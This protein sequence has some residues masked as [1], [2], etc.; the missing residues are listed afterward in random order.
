MNWLDRGIGKISP[1]WGMRR[2]IARRRLD[3]L[4][5][6]QA[7][8]SESRRSFE[9]VSGDRLR[10][11]FSTTTL[12]ADSIIAS[13]AKAV[14]QNVR[15][16]EYNSGFVAGPLKRIVDNVIGTGIRFQAA[17]KAAERPGDPP[18]S[19]DQAEAFN[20]QVERLWRKW[21][22]QAD[23]RLISSFFELQA[24]V[25]GAL[26]RD[27]EA[28]VVGRSSGRPGRLISYCHELLEIDRLGTPPSLIGDRQV[29]NGIRFDSE[30]VQQSYYVL[31]SHPRD[32]LSALAGFRSEDYEEIPAWNPNGTR[33]VL[34]L[35][36]PLRPEQTRGFSEFA[37][38]LKDLQD[39]DRYREAEIMA[40]LEDACLTGFVKT[41]TPSQFQDDTTTDNQ[42]VDSGSA[43]IHEFAPNKWHYLKPGEDVKIHAPSRPG[44]QFQNTLDLLLSGTANAMNIPPEILSQNWKNMNYSNARTVLLQWYLFCRIVQAYIITHYCIPTYQNV[45]NG[46]VA[47]GLIEARG[48]GQWQDE[49]SESTWTPPGWQW[50]DPVKEAQGTQIDLENSLD[51]LTNVLAARGLDIEETLE[52]RAWELK[53]IK[54]LEEK[55]GVKFPSPDRTGKAEE[56]GEQKQEELPTLQ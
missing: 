51:T 41:D 37:A 39:L 26:F 14:R 29:L 19:Q 3:W 5:S 4:R 25:A 53:R 32:T 42:D 12:S 8:F 6:Q 40:A 47:A 16:L 56:S 21:T 22:R 28:L 44:S 18:F 31:R 1:S 49:Y 9:A 17:V 30:G 46:F 55:Y 2:M 33:K 7:R 23:K 10:Y 36:R 45:L 48:F 20:R 35:Y 11:D 43:R 24:Q 27:G 15:Q 52:R 54:E 38:G 34:H 13:G 50:V